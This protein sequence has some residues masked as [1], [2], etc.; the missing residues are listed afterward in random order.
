MSQKTIFFI[1][2]NYLNSF[3]RHKGYT[4]AL[5]LEIFTI[6]KFIIK[7]P[8]NSNNKLIALANFI[9]W[10][11]LMRLLGQKA[12]VPWVDES[13]IICGIGETGLTGNLYAGFMEYEDMLFLLHALQPT[14]TFV[15]I[16][17]N[18][19]A[20][21]I[22]ASKVVESNCIAYEPLSDTVERLRDQIQ[23]N[24]IDA[25]VNIRNVGV[26]DSEGFLFFTNNKDTVNQVS[27]EG[28]TANTTLVKVCTLNKELE[29][30]NKYFFKID[31][32]GFEYNVLNGAS[33]ILSEDIVSAII[34]ELN[35]RGK[36]FGYSNEDVHKQL[37]GY[38]F[39]PVK[40][41]PKSRNI[42]RLESYNKKNGNTIYLKDLALFSERC[43]LAPKRVIHTAHGIKI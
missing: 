41:D 33:E 21:T 18:T 20:Y 2:K 38:G 16:G 9:K 36:E 8:L 31:V 43:K 42:T 5:F 3:I 34:I 19:G 22:L 7:H 25:K 32:E 11:L 12:V 28:G 1:R 13:R 27:R 4:L 15:D 35:G 30:N 6:I 39:S 14:E 10:Q 24:R 37:L 29:K 40:Y 23:I 17:A 26:G